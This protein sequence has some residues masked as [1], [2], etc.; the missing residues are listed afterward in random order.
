MQSGTGNTKEWLLEFVTVARKPLD[1]LMGWVGQSDTKEQL[2]LYFST[3]EEALTYAKRKGYAV[4]SSK[5]KVRKIIPK[6]YSD[7]FSFNKVR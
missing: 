6:S 4:I 1:D 5:P 3:E 7:N 2:K